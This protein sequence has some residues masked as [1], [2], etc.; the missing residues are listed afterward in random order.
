M[1]LTDQTISGTNEIC[2]NDS[3]NTSL[4]KLKVKMTADTVIPSSNDL[5]IYVDKS[6][7]S[8]PTDERKQ[9]VFEL[10]SPLKY[11]N[12]VGD[13][14]VEQISINNNEVTLKATVKR[15][16]GTNDSGNYVLDEILEE[17]VD[18][19][20]IT[21]FEGINYIYTNYSDA[22]IT[23]I[24]PKDNELNR[25][26][27]NNVIYAEHIK[28]NSSEFNLSDLYFK[29][30]FTKTNNKLNLEVNNAT[31]DCLLS[32]NNKFSLDSEGNLTV[33]SITS[34]ESQNNI[35]MQDVRDF[36]YPVGSI[37]MSISSTSPATLFGGT[38]ERINGYY[39]YAGT[40]GNTSGS[41]T[42]GGPSNNNTGSTA[43][44]IAQM[45][46]HTHT[47]NAHNHAQHSDTWM[48]DANN[49][50]TR[51]SGTTGYYAG[52]GL[53]TYYTTSTTATNQNTGGG[54]GHTHS[55]NSHTHSVTPLRYEVYMWKR[56]A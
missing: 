4:L 18:S 53:A 37:Y 38:W 26:F 48:N 39:L 1:D 22:N 50:D 54:Q 43:I 8:T 55:L 29:D 16:I 10:S 12:Q 41:N 49:R 52:A 46:S 5:I 34:E 31:V 11:F 42:S 24:Y 9:Y 30:A 3:I 21:L 25:S 13:E 2:L 20:P 33:K 40:G 47:Q 6:T 7:S 32:K 45:P 19:I 28:N 23:V 44:T 14:L 56:T 51:I 17:I 27:L 36:I 35:N 15:Y